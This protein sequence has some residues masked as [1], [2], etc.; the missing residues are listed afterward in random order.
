MPCIAI[1]LAVA[2]KYLEK[3]PTENYKEF[4]LGTIAP[5]FGCPDIDKY[6]ILNRNDKD[7]RHF[8]TNE[9]ITS[10]IDY[11]KRKVNFELFF[12]NN[13]INS[14]FL[15]AY[16]LHL[17]CDYYF[18]DENMNDGKL[19]GLSYEEAIKVGYNDYDLI[20]EKIVSKYNL[21]IPDMVKD[22]FKR[23]GVGELQIL[24]EDKVYEYIDRMVNID[25][26]KEKK[27]YRKSK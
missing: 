10:V 15:R 11:L 9:E 20:T 27:I 19:N 14:S 3:H 8:G 24:N 13:D 1:H 21:D 26:E 18:Y 4:I 2:K 5:D 16:F 17:L 22:I 12:A 25:L 23:K 7:G 6:I